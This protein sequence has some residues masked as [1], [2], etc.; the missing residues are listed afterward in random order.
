MLVALMVA[1]LL[2]TLVMVVH[3]VPQTQTALIPPTQT[4]PIFVSE[5][6]FNG[7]GDGQFDWLSE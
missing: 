3:R 6:G 2:A 1:M 5:W 7:T 4:P